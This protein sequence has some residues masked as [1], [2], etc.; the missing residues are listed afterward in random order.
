M[1]GLV[2]FNTLIVIVILINLSFNFGKKDFGFKK[3]LGPKRF[4]GKK[5]I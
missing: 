4:S 1:D 3:I 2:W 5:N